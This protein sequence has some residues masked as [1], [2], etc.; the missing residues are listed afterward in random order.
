MVKLLSL[1]IEENKW[2]LLLYPT[3]IDKIS[4]VI[5]R[6]V[7]ISSCEQISLMKDSNKKRYEKRR[8]DDAD[9]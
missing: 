1:K 3:Q 4:N 7:D 8:K 5:N 2:I 9:K 6:W